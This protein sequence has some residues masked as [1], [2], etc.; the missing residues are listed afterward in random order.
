MKTYKVFEF[1]E[2]KPHDP[3]GIIVDMKQNE[4]VVCYISIV[5]REDEDNN[6]ADNFKIDNE[7][8]KILPF[9]RDQRGNNQCENRIIICGPSFCGKTYIAKKYAKEYIKEN[10]ENK[11]IYISCNPKENDNTFACK[12]CRNDEYEYE[13]ND[14][15]KKCWCE[16][17]VYRIE[18]TEDWLDEPLTL[19]ELSNSLVI[20]DDFEA[21][22]SKDLKKYILGLR[23]QIFKSGRH[24]NIS[25]L[26]L[27]QKLLQ[28][29]D[30][31]I[32]L[33]NTWQLILFPRSSGKYDIINYFK[34]YVK[35]D[36][37]VI[38]RILNTKSRWMLY[39]IPDSYI[40]YENSGLIL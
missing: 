21:S 12:N 18:P 10:P 39:D 15:K 33:Q 7:N 20:F 4:K 3:I 13:G 40:L 9:P 24:H 1:S 11:I 26:S 30:S 35:L 29:K 31:I 38:D 6:I 16:K 2:N 5:D 8:L 32:A 27:A 19:D 34:N 28:G 23:D 25:V 22:C 36:T 14:K 37:R 17:Y